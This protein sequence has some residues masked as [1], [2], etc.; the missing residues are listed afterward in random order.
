MTVI[1]TSTGKIQEVAD[2]DGPMTTVAG[3]RQ[4]GTSPVTYPDA[5]PIAGA[6]T[7]RITRTDGQQE[8][9]SPPVVP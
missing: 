3:S 7:S 9:Y 4:N 5:E 1:L 8:V 6:D 2:A